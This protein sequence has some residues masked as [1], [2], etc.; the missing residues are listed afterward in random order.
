MTIKS[1]I[2]YPRDD[3]S[4]PTPPAVGA[5]WSNWLPNGDSEFATLVEGTASAD[6]N[7]YSTRQGFSAGNTYVGTRG[8]IHKTSDLSLFRSTVPFSN[9]WVF[10]PTDDNLAVGVV[11]NAIVEWN[12]TTNTQTT[13]ASGFGSSVSIGSSEG[14]I[15]WDGAYLVVDFIDGDAKVGVVDMAAGQL[16]PTTVSI[17]SLEAQATGSSPTPFTYDNSMISAGGN[18]VLIGVKGR[19]YRYTRSMSNQTEIVDSDYR[20]E[21]G[22]HKVMGYDTVGREIMLAEGRKQNDA[23][24][25]LQ[26]FHLTRDPGDGDEHYIVNAVDLP[27]TAK[28]AGHVSAAVGINGLFGF[29]CQFEDDMQGIDNFFTVEITGDPATQTNTVTDFGKMGTELDGY[30][31]EAI[32]NL[33]PNGTWVT[34]RMSNGNDSIRTMIGRLT[35]ATPPPAGVLEW[36]GFQPQLTD[37][38]ALFISP[39]GNSKP[40]TDQTA[41]S[42]VTAPYTA[43]VWTDNGAVTSFSDG[44]YWKAWQVD[45]GA[46]QLQVTGGPDDNQ[47]N[48]DGAADGAYVTQYGLFSGVDDSV[49]AVMTWS[50]NVGVYAW[51]TTDAV[52]VDGD[53]GSFSLAP[54]LNGSAGALTEQPDNPYL[55][56]TGT[57]VVVD[58]AA[59]VAAQVSSTTATLNDVNGDPLDFTVTVELAISSYPVRSATSNDGMLYRDEKSTKLQL[60]RVVDGQRVF[61]D[62]ETV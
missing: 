39:S 12:I 23:G 62:V 22:S 44:D 47:V 21:G 50:F 41:P 52:T 29:S 60:C 9:E 20:I 36:E 59:M 57:T 53:S 55:S 8:K 34:W 35:T 51:N 6:R 11:G 58:K 56:I 5:G 15:S 14:S 19:L 48:I 61:I 40:I 13:I 33:S 17:P 7:L 26:V 45:N 43:F 16:L 28:I 38:G 18:F 30:N 37:T 27:N 10:H 25:N 4:N 2:S 54:Y 1:Q 46:P 31:N 49:K 42:L 32:G 24:S 3:Y